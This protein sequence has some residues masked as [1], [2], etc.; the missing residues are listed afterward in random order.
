MHSTKEDIIVAALGLFQKKGF[1]ETSVNDILKATGLSKGGLYHH[2]KSKE[3]IAD[4]II[5]QHIKKTKDYIDS[6][7][8]ENMS[9]LEKFLLFIFAERE[10]LSSKEAEL[11]M[12]ALYL[13]PKASSIRERA[14]RISREYFLAPLMAVLEEGMQSGDFDIDSPEICAELILSFENLVT[15]LPPEI[16]NDPEKLQTCIEKVY[17]LIAQLVGI[18]PNVLNDHC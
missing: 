8:E 9:P 15:S 10:V 16:L 4:S 6:K 7:L 5:I 12:M 18:D 13:S 17:S 3:E 11:N 14:K 2:F 1:E